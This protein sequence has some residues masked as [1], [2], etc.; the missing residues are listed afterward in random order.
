VR[1]K[2]FKQQNNFTKLGAA[3]NKTSAD[4]FASILREQDVSRN[5]S[6]QILR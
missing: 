4:S 5:S 3:L 2:D 6:S 1:T